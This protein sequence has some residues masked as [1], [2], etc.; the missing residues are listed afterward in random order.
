MRFNIG[1][2]ASSIR[3]RFVDTFDRA[4]SASDLGRATDGSLWTVLRGT[5]GISSNKASSSTAPSSYPLATIDMPKQ[6]VQIDLKDVANGTGAALWV[7]DSGNWW[8]IAVDQET[9]TTYSICGGSNCNAYTY[10]SGSNCNSYSTNCNSTS[11]ACFP[12]GYLYYYTYCSGT[13]NTSNCTGFNASTCSAYNS[14]KNCKSYNAS[15]CKGYNA[16]NCNSF[17]TSPQC[18]ISPGYMYYNCNAYSTNCSA[19][20]SY[21]YY[22]CSSAFYYTYECNPVTTYPVYIRLYQ[23][24]ANT[25]SQIASQT[26]SAMAQ[27]LRIVTSGS[28]ITTK[29]Y[30]DTDQV[31]QVDSD[32]VYTPTGVALTPKYGIVVTPTNYNQGST[33]GDAQIS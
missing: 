28:Q 26:L 6:D 30:S 14:T 8:G 4:D 5:W 15:N 2:I 24:V 31:I 27:S 11:V 21:S 19:Y 25:V 10:V 29:A 12:P 7:T 16:S 9:V 3:K 13:Y 23:S 22:Y 1:S 18:N 32:W 17:A 20:S 33:I